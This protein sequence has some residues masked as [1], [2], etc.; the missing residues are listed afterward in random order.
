MTGPPVTRRAGSRPAT[1][2]Q[3]LHQVKGSPIICS[4]QPWT[5]EVRRIAGL[6]SA[7]GDWKH[8]RVLIL[9]VWGMALRYRQGK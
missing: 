2:P 8:F 7:T 4:S 5:R 3:I 9:H 6:F 1:S